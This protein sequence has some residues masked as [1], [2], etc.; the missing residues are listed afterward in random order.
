M[1]NHNGTH[2]DIKGHCDP[3]DQEAREDVW[4]FHLDTLYPKALN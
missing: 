4:I 3:N 2:E 1:L